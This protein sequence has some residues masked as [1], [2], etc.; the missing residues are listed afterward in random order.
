MSVD[1]DSEAGRRLKVLV[2]DDEPHNIDVL[3]RALQRQY[4]FI[5]AK[6]ADEALALL[7]TNTDIAVVISDQRM[8]GELSGVDLLRQ[9]AHAMPSVVRIILSGYSKSTDI[10]Q[11]INAGYVD[12]FLGKPVD[13]QRLIGTVR[14]S[15]QIYELTSRFEEKARLLQSRQS[16]LDQMLKQWAHI[17]KVPGTACERC[18][19]TDE[20]L[21]FAAECLRRGDPDGALMALREFLREP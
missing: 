12:R 7:Q 17:A 21:R 6:T 10:L 15:L 2:V 19:K 5:E 9:V 4:D 1:A 11:A 16:D 20:V 18:Q 13:V 14:E 8:P 3:R